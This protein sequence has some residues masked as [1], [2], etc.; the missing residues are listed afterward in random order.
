MQKEIASDNN[1]IMKDIIPIVSRSRAP[2]NRTAGS[3]VQYRKPEALSGQVIG[4]IASSHFFIQDDVTVD[5]L[6]MELN[7]NIAVSSVGVIEKAG[8]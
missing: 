5:D 1:L 2:H 8:L 4:R 6:L 7:R 3:V